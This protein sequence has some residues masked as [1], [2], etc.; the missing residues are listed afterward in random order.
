MT[1][2]L[3]KHQQKVAKAKEILEKWQKNK[4]PAAPSEMAASNTMRQKTYKSMMPPLNLRDWDQVLSVDADRKIAVV[5]PG[6][7]ME[8][9]VDA[10]LPYGLIPPVVPEFK[11]I[12]VGGAINGAAIESSSHLYGQF[13]DICLSYEI[14]LGDGTVIKAS[15]AEHAELFYGIAGSYGTLGLLLSVELRLIPAKGFVGV[16][17]RPYQTVA[18]TLDGVVGLHRMEKPPEFLEAVQFKNGLGAVVYGNSIDAGAAYDMPK[19]GFHHASD[20]WF[21]SF[22]DGIA[23]ALLPGQEYEV[24]IP[25]RDYLFRHDRGA[26]WMAGF[27][28]HLPIIMQYLMHKACLN[29]GLDKDS[30][31]FWPGYALPKN[32]GTLFR[33]LFGWMVGSQWLYKSLHG[34]SEK[35]FEERFVIQDFYLPTENALAFVEA[36]DERYAIYPIWICPVRATATPQLFS[37]HFHSDDKL[38]IDI[39]IYGLPKDAHGP[40]A[41][42]D[43]EQLT[44]RLGGRKMFYC[45]T[46]IPLKEFWEIYPRQTYH[47]LRQKYA[48]EGFIPEITQKVLK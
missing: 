35:W 43:L 33:Q 13:N 17:I 31:W 39:G 44:H 5:E 25:L 24:A 12:T 34:G 10:L 15:P 41:V 7:S 28:L 40:E 26:F 1:S 38:M 48:L 47:Q 3:T 46:Y 18:E 19:A 29:I 20:P 6:I 27:A 2:N 4:A 11:G 36:V 42:R 30:K 32:P 21:Y 22:V 37:P 23:T 45:H 14:L 9:L 8:A 16:V